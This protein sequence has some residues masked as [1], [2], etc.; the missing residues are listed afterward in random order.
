MRDS[1]PTRVHADHVMGDADGDLHEAHAD[2]PWP[3]QPRHAREC[4]AESHE[5]PGGHHLDQA[6][7]ELADAHE[8]LLLREIAPDATLDQVQ[9]LT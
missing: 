2:E 5:R 6:L 9:S 7:H 4:L 8:G 3:P 1:V